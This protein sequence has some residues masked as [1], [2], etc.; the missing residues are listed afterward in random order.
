MQLLWIL[1]SVTF[2]SS[3]VA[4]PHGGWGSSWGPVLPETTATITATT[5]VTDTVTST[6]TPPPTAT[7]LTDAQATSIVHQYMTLLVAPGGPDFNTTAESLLADSF[8][9]Y[10]DSINQLSHEPLGGYSYPSKQAFIDGQAKTPPIPVLKTYSIFY[11][12]DRIAW[13]WVGSSIG[14][15]M[16]E[17]NGIITMNITSAGQIAVVYSEFNTGAWLADIGYPECN[18]T[19]S[20]S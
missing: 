11:N 8:I 13:R 1:P 17:V 4:T 18:T 14:S 5:T 16:S 12:C 9:V 3:V 19:A 15:N 6:V 2:A 20:A 7:C 10:S